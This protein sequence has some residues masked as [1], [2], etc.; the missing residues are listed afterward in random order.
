[1]ISILVSESVMVC[2]RE[3]V[4]R[5]KREKERVRHLLR[6]VILLIESVYGD[7]YVRVYLVFCE[8]GQIGQK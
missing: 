2:L 6:S 1:M 7:V 4:L 3:S 5:R 8:K